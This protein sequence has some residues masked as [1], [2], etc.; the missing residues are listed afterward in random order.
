MSAI[1]QTNDGHGHETGPP[2]DP[3]LRSQLTLQEG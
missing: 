1:T 3:P 2:D